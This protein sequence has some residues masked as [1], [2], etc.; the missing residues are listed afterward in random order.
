[1]KPDHVFSRIH[2]AD[3]VQTLW[4]S[5]GSPQPGAIYNV[6]DDEP[7]EPSTLIVEGA[8][9]LG[10]PT[11]PAQPYEASQLSPMAASFWSECRRVSNRKIKEQLK[12]QLAYPTY[13]EGLSAIL[14]AESASPVG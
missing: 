14:A 11:P 1:V 10:I 9:L 8:R 12:V 5:M 7:S 4:C 3:I 6:A 2:V 13:R